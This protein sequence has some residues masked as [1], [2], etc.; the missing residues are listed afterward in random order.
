M[1]SD[2][3]DFELTLAAVRKDFGRGHRR[4]TA[5]QPVDLSLDAHSELGVI[6]E[7]GSGKSTLA[8]MIVGLEHPTSGLISYQGR[9]VAQW[10][11][12][13]AGRIA[14]R[15]QVQYVAQDTTSFDPRQTFFESVSVP[16]RILRGVRG[17]QEIRERLDAIADD[18]SLDPT[19]F[20]RYPHQVSG[21][22][23]QRFA[24]ARSLVVEPRLLIC[25]EV[26]SALDVSVQGAVLNLIK[27]H[28]ARH[29]MGLMFVAHGLPAVTFISSELLVMRNGEVVERG[30]VDQVVN[31][32]QHPYTRE[33][34]DAYVDSS[35][36]QRREAAS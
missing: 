12:S 28:V 6:G 1:T 9:S 36:P 25:D 20:S 15:Q 30:A 31:E 13:R 23:R 2:D 21:G 26:V 16:L 11:S 24:L 14:Y 27:R 32:P 7:S 8:R 18:L 10:L 34:L 33:L 35:S 22:Q 29:R 19:L 3:G 4:I 17:R 5:V